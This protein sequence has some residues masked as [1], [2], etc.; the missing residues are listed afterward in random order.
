MVLAVDIRT[1]N[2]QFRHGRIH[3][4]Y[5]CIS[6]DKYRVSAEEFKCWPLNAR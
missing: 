1:I 4:A 6:S 3:A 2:V 5:V